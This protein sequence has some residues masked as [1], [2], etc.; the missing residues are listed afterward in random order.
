MGNTSVIRSATLGALIVA[1]GFVLAG[2]APAA[3][4]RV[5]SGAVRT[6]VNVV[7]ANQCQS[8]QQMPVF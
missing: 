8:H 4:S 2:K 5:Q 1:G 6:A 3:E 7:G